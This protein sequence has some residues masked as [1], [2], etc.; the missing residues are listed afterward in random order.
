M[1]GELDGPPARFVV[2]VK[3]EEKLA[4]VDERF[5]QR[6]LDLL[7]RGG[8]GQSGREDRREGALLLGRGGLSYS[9]LR[10]GLLLARP[11]A[12]RRGDGVVNGGGTCS[13]VVILE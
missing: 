13:L 4:R 9:W 11:G 7:T 10:A 3:G 5:R 6:V 12:E 2:V 1:H 8:S